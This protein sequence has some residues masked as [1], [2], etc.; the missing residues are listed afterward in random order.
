MP[1][2]P[3]VADAKPAVAE[4]SQPLPFAM[5]DE[6]PADKPVADAPSIDDFLP[7]V[8]AQEPESEDEDAEP[9]EEEAPAPVADE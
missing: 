5:P 3:A 8:E 9:Y 2:Q 6:E 7:F 1:R 4:V